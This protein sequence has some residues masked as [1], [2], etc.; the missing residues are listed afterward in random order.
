MDILLDK[1]VAGQFAHMEAVFSY[2]GAR[3]VDTLVVG[4][5]ITKLQ[6]FA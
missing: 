6:A 1:R 3:E 4:R 5:E 2:G